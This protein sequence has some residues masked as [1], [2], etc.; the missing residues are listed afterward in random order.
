MTVLFNRRT[1]SRSDLQIITCVGCYTV[2]KKYENVL[3][4]S[5]GVISDEEDQ[6]P[7]GVSRESET[8]KNI[9]QKEGSL[10]L[11]FASLGLRC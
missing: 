5:G 9:D 11:F 10:F 7:D 8:F 1:G 6:C 4:V 2:I 3:S